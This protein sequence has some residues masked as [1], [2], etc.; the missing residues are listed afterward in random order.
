M[1]KNSITFYAYAFVVFSILFAI[2]LLIYVLSLTEDREFYI[3]DELTHKEHLNK[4]GACVIKHAIKRDKADQLKKSCDDKAYQAVKKHIL[5]DHNLIKVISDAT[6]SPDYI[7]QDYIWIIQKSSVHTCHRDNNGDFFNIGQKYPSYTM[8]VYLE[9]MERCLSVIPKSH[10]DVNS[11][12]IDFNNS[13]RTIIC[14][15]GDAVIFNA[16][17]I[18]VGCINE[19]DD[20]IRVQLK[21]THKSDIP[22]I[23]YYQN[24]NKVLNEDNNIP[25]YMRKMQQNM[26]CM[27]PGI[28]NYTQQENINSARGSDNGA[29]I[30]YG[31]KMFSYLFYGNE[32]YYD[33][34]NFS[35]K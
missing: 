30:G 16:N 13:L 22:H 11:H 6:G 33:L 24:Y 21:V 18:H 14:N 23:S 15:K 1:K 4:Y 2:V 5:N 19:K 8:L 29:K 35:S 20:N 28:S 34:K 7:F 27:F 31:Q 10:K 12:F 26:S 17:L 3:N 25:K 9:D 32:N